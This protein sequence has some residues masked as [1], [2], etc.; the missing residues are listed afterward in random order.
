MLIFCLGMKWVFTPLLLITVAV[1]LPAEPV[2]TKKSPQGKP[3]ASSPKKTASGKTASSHKSVRT[4]HSRSRRAKRAPAPAYQLHPD[5]SRY[6]E[7]QKALADRGYFKGEVNGQWNDDSVDALKRFQA[8]QKLDGDGK[9]DA[10]TLIGLGLGP[11]HDASLVRP[12]LPPPSSSPPVVT[13][14]VTQPNASSTQETTP[15][16]AAP[17]N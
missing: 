1:F 10:L 6:A 7:I 12:H 2:K 3:A 16:P 11:K 13:T 9:I 8:D 17:P 5:P 4:T 14:P 15:A